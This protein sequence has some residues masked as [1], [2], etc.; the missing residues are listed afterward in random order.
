MSSRPAFRRAFVILTPFA[1]AAGI[2]ACVSGLP[3]LENGPADGGPRGDD[4]SDR[5]V[6]GDTKTDAGADGGPAVHDHDAGAEASSDAGPKTDAACGVPC[7][8]PGLIAWYRADDGIVADATGNVQRWKDQSGHANDHVLTA[9][10]AATQPTLESN[11][12]NGHP[13][14]YFVHQPNAVT[15]PGPLASAPFPAVLAQPF[16]EFVATVPANATVDTW[17]ITWGLT[18]GHAAG[19][20]YS[21]YGTAQSVFLTAGSPIDKTD[22][23]FNVF[24]P[25]FNSLLKGVWTGVFD[26]SCSELAI[27]GVAR[28]TGSAGGNRLDGVS[29][30]A[31][32]GYVG[33][34]LVYGAVLSVADRATINAYLK[35]RWGF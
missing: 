6:D 11:G 32:P 27:N 1:L 25:S 18:P 28:V 26:N 9:P 30:G 34:F 13:A 7:S 17:N 19:F 35:A 3:P 22:T 20:G 12:I 29:I 24:T 10:D 5:A 23:D 21:Y 31:F 15:A 16:T 2:G 14:V 8:V 4:S 33:E